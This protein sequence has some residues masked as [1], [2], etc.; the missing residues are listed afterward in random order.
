[1]KAIVEMFR[2]IV[3]KVEVKKLDYLKT[4]N[5]SIKQ[6]NYQHG[7]YT[8]I[9]ASLINYGK[10][11]KYTEMKYPLIALFEDVSINTVRGVQEA[12]FSMLI[13]YDSK[14]DIRSE[15]RYKEVIN[16]ILYPLYNELIKQIMDSGYFIGYNVSHEM[17]THPYYGSDKRPGMN[18]FSDI[19]DSVELRNIRLKLYDQIDC[20]I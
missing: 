9:H 3:K 8:E 16:L 6:I 17:I 20:Q 1:M 11:L 5:P 7:H 2:E 4:I 14:S 13:C 19:L 12:R 10:T 15:E 18:V